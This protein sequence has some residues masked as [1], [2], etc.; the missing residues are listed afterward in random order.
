MKKTTFEL[1]EGLTD[2]LRKSNTYTN[3]EDILLKKILEQQKEYLLLLLDISIKTPSATYKDKPLIDFVKSCYDNVLIQV[4]QLIECTNLKL[5]VA[6]Q[7]ET[8]I[9]SQEVES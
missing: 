9:E 8:L 1:M 3:R 2:Y 4:E 5:D 6:N 7:L